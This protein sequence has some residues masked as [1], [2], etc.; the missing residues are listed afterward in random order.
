VSNTS[1][2]ALPALASDDPLLRLDAGSPEALMNA[3]LDGDARAFELLFRLL[4]PRVSAVLGQLSG[5][6]RL[7]ED[8]TQAVFLKVY[9]ARAMYRRGMLVAP[10]VFAI[11]R[12]TF[13]DHRRSM[14]R[15]PERLSADGQLPEPRQLSVG[16]DETAR[17]MLYESLQELPESQRQAL[18][19]LK[20]HGLS[21]AEAAAVCGTSPASI[22]M[23]AHRAYVHLRDALA[24][25]A[26]S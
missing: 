24:R 17:A 14:A 3:F 2:P 15:R 23:R 12:N 18:I 11:A 5:D 13:A 6:A 7:S 8:L 21:L 4:A 26:A 16:L 9:R 10:W 19:L 1:S 25:K 22:K 20:V